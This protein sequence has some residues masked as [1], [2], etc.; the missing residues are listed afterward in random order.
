MRIDGLLRFARNDEARF[1]I[2][3]ARNDRA[4]QR[5]HPRK[6]EGAGNAGCRPHPQPRAQHKKQHTSIVTTGQPNS[7]AFPARWSFRL[8]RALPGVP[9][10]LAPIAAQSRARLDPSV[11]G[12]GPHGLT[13]RDPAARLAAEPAS[14]AT[15]ATLRDDRETPSVTGA[16]WLL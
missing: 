12:S 10:L 8:L 14:I 6:T 7:P 15:R 16:G 2:P 1:R 9:G 11:R 3:A 13:V 5:S 4:L